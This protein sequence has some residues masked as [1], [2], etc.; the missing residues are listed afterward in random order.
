MYQNSFGLLLGSCADRTLKQLF[1]TS[2]ITGNNFLGSISNR[3]LLIMENMSFCILGVGG[4]EFPRSNVTD[5]IGP[6]LIVGVTIH[7]ADIP[8]FYCWN[9]LLVMQLSFVMGM[10]LWLVVLPSF[11]RLCVF[12]HVV[13]VV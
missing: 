4:A 13:G 3:S 11:N 7:R 1:K 9:S 6:A 2:L 10:G 5:D 12:M 8:L